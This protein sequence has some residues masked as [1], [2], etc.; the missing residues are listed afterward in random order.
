MWSMTLRDT[1]LADGHSGLV[2]TAWLIFC[3]PSASLIVLTILKI[4]ENHYL[5]S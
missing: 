3:D 2:D 1:K 4:C 5:L